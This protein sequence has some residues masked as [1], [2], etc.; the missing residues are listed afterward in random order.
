MLT[1]VKEQL[2]TLASD[3]TD[4]F[5]HKIRRRVGKRATSILE[6]KLKQFILLMP[7]LVSRIHQHWNRQKSKSEIKKLGGFLL[8]YLYHPQDFISE[9]EQGLF[10]YLDDAYLVAVVYEAVLKELTEAG[11]QLASEDEKLRDEVKDLQRAATIVIP[12]EAEKINRMVEE[13]LEGNRH[14]FVGLF[15]EEGAVK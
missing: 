6:K 10:G 7:I 8:A 13:I 11:N 12:K 1:A 3:P 14:T 2:K 4:Q 9:A 15:N 5:H